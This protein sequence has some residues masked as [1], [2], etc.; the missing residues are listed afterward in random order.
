MNTITAFGLDLLV[1]LLVSSLLFGYLRPS[2]YR[3][4]VDLC[5]GEDRA[6]FWIAF[7]AVMLLGVP[8]AYA[9]GYT[10]PVDGAQAVF[11]DVAHQLGRNLAGLLLAVMGLGL[12]VG[13]FALV[14]PRTPKER[15]S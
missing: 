11:F 1:T 4:L 5:G 12:A 6:R 10:P 14:A 3:V 8:G 15:T 13:F 7:T 2:L 9:L